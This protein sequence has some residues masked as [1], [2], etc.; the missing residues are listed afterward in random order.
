MDK[1][2]DGELGESKKLIDALDLTATIERL[3]KVHNWTRNQATE[4]SKQYR[5]YLFLKKKY[6]DDYPLPPSYDIDDVWHAHI[7]HTEDYYNFC[8]QVFGEFLHHHP[9]HGKDNS[10][11]DTD[12]EKLF[13]KTQELYYLEFQEPI[14]NIRPVPLKVKFQKF[15]KELRTVNV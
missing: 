10:I 1:F 8:K 13:E 2:S 9:H 12:I 14:C 4:A 5:N 11:T 3:V 15:L 7:L 6:G